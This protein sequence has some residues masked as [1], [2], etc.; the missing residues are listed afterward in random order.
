MT[1]DI[2]AL[3]IILLVTVVF[4]IIELFR[5]DVI[6]IMAML[7]LVWVGILTP[8]EAFSGFSSNAAI[9]IIGIMIIGF[10]VEKSGLMNKISA[11]IIKFAGKNENKL[12]TLVSLS[13][14]GISSFIPN[15]GA[16]A[17]FLP[18]IRRI[19]GEAR[20]PVSRLLMPMG[21]AAILGG[22]LTMVGSAPML[23][24]NDLAAGANLPVFNLFS[25]TPIGLALLVS[26]ILYF[27]FIGKYLLPRREI[28]EECKN[29][30]QK[31]IDTFDLQPTIFLFRI[32][33]GC[34]LIGKTREEVQ[35][36]K[37]YNLHLLALSE[38][39]EVTYAPW[40][41]TRFSAG[42]ELAVLGK[43]EDVNRLFEDFNLQVCNNPCHF[44]EII[45]PESAGFSELIVLPGSRV[46][47]KSFRR[48]AFRKTYDVEPV[49]LIRGNSE[50]RGDFA[51]IPLR[52]G[53]III[54][55]S[56]WEK[57]QQF[58]KNDDFVVP[59]PVEVPPRLKGKSLWAGI[60]FLGVLAGVIAGLKLPLV[61]MTGAMV[62]VLS[63]TLTIDEAYHAVD[64]RTLFLLAGLIPLGIAMEKTGA[65]VFI[66]RQL[67]T[68]VSNSPDIVFLLAVGLLT[69]LFS[70]FMSNAAAVVL[71]V[72]L[73]VKL[74]Q[75][76]GVDPG[77]AAMLVAIC[78]S[79]SFVLP[80]HQVNAFLMSPGGYRTKDYIK[81]GGFM[82]IVF[83]VVSVAVI[84]LFYI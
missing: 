45:S 77:A 2:L 25:S 15:I 6:A 11:S 74:A 17:L 12:I 28:T 69:T 39:N 55:Y 53:D 81:A 61:L 66:S 59:T 40:R 36:W 26:G 23:L 32:P 41:M 18:A 71:L 49:I 84:Y 5:V 4:F 80:T 29:R 14:G 56:L 43:K 78:A 38:N 73:V 51:D 62:M 37:T 10:G 58:K 63:K 82:T 30:L 52:P 60:I 54:I 16:A 42:Q 24:L 64:W 27:V 7:A 22:T 57:I 72:P 8:S 1:P 65:A 46:V 67:M 76:A 34:P 35:L 33:E 83:L 19:A 13:V 21:F 79:N 31:L 9:S 44:E 75:S 50:K 20:M 68:V 48:L 70:L 47:G 3:S